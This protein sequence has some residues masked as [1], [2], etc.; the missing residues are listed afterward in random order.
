MK[1]RLNVI[2]IGS[3]TKDVFLISKGFKIIK[4]K[5]FSTGY[6]EC[7]VYG[8]KV[9]L[10]GVYFDTGGGATNAAATCASLGLTTGVVTSVGKDAPGIEVILDLKKRGVVVSQIHKHPQLNTGYSTILLADSGD[11][12]ILVYRG[13]SNDFNPAYIT[14]KCN[15]DW[16]Y[17][18][19]VGGNVSFLK[20]VFTQARSNKSRIFWNPGAK[21]LAHG[22]SFLTPYLKSTHILSLNT[23]EAMELCKG[24][25]V[26]TNIKKLSKLVPIVLITDGKN[27]A[28]MAHGDAVYFIPT[29]GTKPL[30]ATGAGDA[31]GSGFLSGYIK[32]GDI[33]V[34]A[35]TGVYNS[36][37]I[38]QTMGAKN[39]IITKLPSKKQCDR[40]SIKAVST[41]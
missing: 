35:C 6:G 36:D 12:T 34:A 40:V 21:E 1:Q 24:K 3:A 10:G 25:D 41:K 18:S 15:A 27:G 7:F 17:L 8:S 30:N 14:K 9:E 28:Y 11:R 39:G 13:A 23:D 37:A 33:F 29:L 38:I 19:S 5:I 20:K 32:T 4:S 2:T 31:F 26:V 22:L 16:L